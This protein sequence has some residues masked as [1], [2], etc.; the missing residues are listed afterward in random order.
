MKEV[1]KII[2]IIKIIALRTVKKYGKCLY[3]ISCGNVGL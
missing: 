1:R 2:K 3:I